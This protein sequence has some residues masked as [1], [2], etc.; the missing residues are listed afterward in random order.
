MPRP[1]HPDGRP[2]RRCPTGPGAAWHRQTGC[3]PGRCRLRLRYLP[4][5]HRHGRCRRRHPGQPPRAIKHRLDT[6]LYRKRHLVECCLSRLKQ[7]R[8]VATRYEKTARNYL[9]MSHPRRNRPLVAVNVHK[10]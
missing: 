2:A 7:F 5:R 8:R 10:T 9:A 6:S 1:D 3:D 4:Q